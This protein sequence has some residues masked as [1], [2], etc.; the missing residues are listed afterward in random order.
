M[1][2]A[3]GRHFTAWRPIAL[4]FATNMRLAE[5][6]SGRGRLRT[7][8]AIFQL[9]ITLHCWPLLFNVAKRV[10]RGIRAA[11]PPA[12]RTWSSGRALGQPATC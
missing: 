4:D 11:D 1:R 6:A 8:F 5:M 3:T 10:N 12:C 7:A 2:L 9:P